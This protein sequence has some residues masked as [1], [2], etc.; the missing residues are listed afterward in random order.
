[1]TP[2]NVHPVRLILEKYKPIHK[3]S[4][5]KSGKRY[6]YSARQQTLIRK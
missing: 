4:K 1:M 6:T 2:K 5:S 3:A